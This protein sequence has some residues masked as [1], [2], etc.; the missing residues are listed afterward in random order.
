MSGTLLVDS[1]CAASIP[2][3]LKRIDLTEWLFT[4]SDADYRSCS[5]QHFAAGASRSEDGRRMSINVERIGET[6]LFEHYVEDISEA[7]H[8]RVVSVSDF[9]NDRLGQATINVTWE[10][11]VE[12][13]DGSGV[14]FTNRV[15]A[16]TTDD[17]EELLNAAGVKVEMV[18][19]SMQQNAAAHN[20]EETPL[21]ARN[22]A[23]RFA[24]HDARNQQ[25]ADTADRA[26]EGVSPGPQPT[27][28][29]T[30]HR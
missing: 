14:T 10:L 17:L 20:A 8:C 16:H 12:P 27:I 28:E 29:R 6:L 24:E 1:H 30:T 22:I 5:T 2:L 25:E 21:F 3:E 4:L 13:A 7:H 23:A 19:D 9:L 11:I 18:R 15:I 26:G